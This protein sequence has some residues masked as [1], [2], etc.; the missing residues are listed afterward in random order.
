MVRGIHSAGFSMTTAVPEGS[1]GGGGVGVLRSNP[2]SMRRWR[3][4]VKGKGI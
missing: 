3:I 4:W 1:G 2:Q